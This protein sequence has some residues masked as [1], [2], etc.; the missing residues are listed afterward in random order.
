MG[1]SF[2]N[3]LKKNQT[4]GLPLEAKIFLSSRDME[5]IA[6]TCFW[7]LEEIFMLLTTL[8]YSKHPLRTYLYTD[9]LLIASFVSKFIKEKVYSQDTTLKMMHKI[10]QVIKQSYQVLNVETLSSSQMQILRNNALV[11]DNCK[12]LIQ[13]LNQNPQII[14]HTCMVK[15]SSN[16]NNNYNNR[17]DRNGPMGKPVIIFY[18]T[19]VALALCQRLARYYHYI[20][21][22]ELLPC[23]D[24]LFP[25]AQVCVETTGDVNQKNINNFYNIV[26]S[27]CSMLY[28]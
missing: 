14:V 27:T 12:E 18:K 5:A 22:I 17:G 20:K 1:T 23:V 15:W 7:H 11:E 9:S 13:N 19:C 24:D 26:S 2:L 10:S 6:T 28:K 4:G 21:Y 25:F 8:L 3:F 16:S